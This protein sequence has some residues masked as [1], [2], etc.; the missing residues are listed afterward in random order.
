MSDDAVA[1][2]MAITSSEVDTAQQYLQAADFNIEQAIELFFA[3]GG[4]SVESQTAPAPADDGVRERIEGFDDQLVDEEAQIYNEAVRNMRRSE[5]RSRRPRGVFNQDRDED[6]GAARM[7]KHERRLASLFRPP[8]DIMT[9]AGLEEA[10]ELAQA[11][12]KLVMVNVQ[13][14]GEFACQRLNRDIWRSQQIKEVV[15]SNF[16]FLQYDSE[17]PD[18]EDYRVLYPFDTFPHIAILD[19]WTGEQQ[20]TWSKV[21]GHDEFIEDLFDFVASNRV[22]AADEMADEPAER[23]TEPAASEPT[24][25]APEPVPAAKPAEADSVAAIEPDSSEEPA[26]GPGT[27]RIQLRYGDGKRTV[28]RFELTAPV[29]AIYGVAKHASGANALTLTADRRDLRSELSTS[30]ED[31]NL[32]NSTVLVEFE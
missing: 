7:S 6:S 26:P 29:A 4:A 21:P 17:D 25:A 28:R 24:P 31:A 2:F 8:F 23:A 12:G 22:P 10:K 15:A 16:V 18:G 11:E 14:P 19:P 32:K 3:S 20:K 27:T 13:N 1:Q 5:V 30:I 9:D